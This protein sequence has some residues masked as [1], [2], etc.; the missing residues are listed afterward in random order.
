MQFPEG[1]EN[2]PF[3]EHIRFSNLEVY[4]FSKILVL[5]LGSPDYFKL[6]KN[7]CC[8]KLSKFT[9]GYRSVDKWMGYGNM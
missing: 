4:M 5:A 6:R 2:I 3:K 9:K 8:C 1:L 7:N